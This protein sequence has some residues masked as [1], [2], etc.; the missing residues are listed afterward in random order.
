MFFGFRS[1]WGWALAA[2]LL[3]PAIASANGAGKPR[4]EVLAFAQGGCNPQA[5]RATAKRLRGAI[6]RCVDGKAIGKHHWTMASSKAGKATNLKGRG[7][8]PPEVAR[9]VEARVEAAT[10]PKAAY[11]DMELTVVAK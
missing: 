7:D 6:L 4:V 10:W 5:V 3:A 8:F 1:N 2:A 11:C 9:C